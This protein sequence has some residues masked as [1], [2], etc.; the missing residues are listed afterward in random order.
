MPKDPRMKRMAAIIVE[1]SLAVNPGEKVLVDALDES[2]DLI[3]A[4]VDAISAAGGLPY[5]LHQ[6]SRVRRTWLRSATDAGFA[7]WYDSV[8]SVRKEMDC[9]LTI[10]GRTT[11]ASSLMC[12]RRPCASSAAGT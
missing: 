5:V 6:T 2:E 4:A 3:I 12:R 10:R 8:A 7:L 1:H 11:P 9:L